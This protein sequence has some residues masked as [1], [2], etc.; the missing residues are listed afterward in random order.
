MPWVVAGVVLLS[1]TGVQAQQAPI[2]DGGGEAME[3]AEGGRGGNV[4]ERGGSAGVP[5]ITSITTDEDL[6]ANDEFTVTV[7]FSEAVDGFRGNDI[8]VDNGDVTSSVR[9]ISADEY[10]FE[11]TPD[12]DFDGVL[13]VRIRTNAVESVSTDDPNA[14]ESETF[15]VDTIE[16]TLEDAT[17]DG[18]ELVLEYSE[19]LDVN[20]VPRPQRFNVEVDGT[21]RFVNDITIRRDRVTLTLES[22]VDRGDRVRIDYEHGSGDRLQDLAGN[23]A[24]E[25]DN[26]RVTN[27]TQ[28][29]TRVPSAPR[30]LTAT[31]DGQTVIELDWRAPSSSGTGG[32]ITGYRIEVSDDGG[33][34]WE[35]EESDTGNDDTEYRHTRLRK[36]E[37]WHYRVS[38]W[39]DEGRGPVSD[40]ASATTDSDV[41]GA[42]TGL[43]ATANG[44]DR[45]DLS[46]TAPTNEGTGIIGYQIEARE[47]TSGSWT[48]LVANTNS[49]GTTY[50]HRNLDPGSTWYYRVAALSS[51]GDGPP[52]NVANATTDIGRPSAP[53]ALSATADGRTRINLAWSAPSDDG[54]APITQYRIEVSRTGTSGWLLVTRTT[55]RSYTHT[56][57]NPGSR[58]FYR[59]AAINSEGQGPFSR[60]ASA[61]TQATVPSAPS[62]LVAT[63]HGQNQINLS[64]RTPISDGGATI[65]GYRIEVSS[66]GGNNWTTRVGN[67]GNT[68]TRYEHKGLNPAST[69]HYRVYAINSAGTGPASNVANA[70][71]D[72]TVPGAPTGLTAT[73]NGQSRID[74]AW[75]APTNDGGAEITGYRIESSSN[76]TSWKT[77][78][79]NHQGTTFSNVGLAPA[80]TR[81]YRVSA[82]NVAGTGPASNIATATTDAT[83]PGPP[84]AL[85]A[86]ADGT[87]KID[88]SWT[89][90]SYDG[91]AAL[92][93][94]RIESAPNGN[95]PWTNLVANTGSTATTHSD[96]GLDPATTRYY[97]VFAINSVGSGR[98]SGVVRATT[99]A[100]VPNAPTGLNAADVSPTQI[101]LTWT[102]PAYDG[103]APITSYRVEISADGGSTWGVLVPSTA[104]TG[105]SYSHIGLE[106]GSTRHYRVSA[107]NI[108]GTGL[109][110]NV[111]SASTDDPVQR[112]GRVNAEVLPHAVAALTA[113]TVSAISGRIEAVAA[114]VPYGRQATMG[115]L[116]S[117][118]GG[119]DGAG[120]GPG[121]GRDRGMGQLFDGAS[122]LLPLG[123]SGMQQAAAG[124]IPNIAAWGSG[125]YQ[126][127]SRSRT[128]SVD[129]DGNMLNM[130]VG[131]DV[132]LR[133]DLLVGVA[134]SRSAGEFDFTDETGAS[135]VDGTY[136][137]EMTTVNPYA[138]WFL[139]RGGVVAW[140]TGGF[141]W[142]DVEI[143]DERQALRRSNTTML[144]GAV[145][146]SGILVSTGSAKLRVRAEGWMTQAEVEGSAE[147]EAMSLEVRRGRLALEWQ[148]GYRLFGGHEVSALVEGGLRYD[149]GDGG[150]GEGAEVGGGLRYASPRSRLI[151]EGRGRVLATGHFGYEEW[152]VSGMIQFDMHRRGEGLSM[153]LAPAWGEA[154]SGVQQL[155]DRGVTD[156]MGTGLTPARARLD[157]EVEYGLADF[158]GTPYGRLY[159]LDGGDRAF[160]T[161]VR[162]EISRVMNMRLE[163]TR[164]ES[165]L[166]GARHGLTL[167]G[168]LKF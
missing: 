31:A 135:E 158:G 62:N 23:E 63:A 32:D 4:A 59:V 155:W 84:T 33:T 148:Q 9:E 43:T 153:R 54:G 128:G 141:G 44:Q 82:V 73:A 24:P 138:A 127:L 152:G 18:D 40:T 88:L 136:M 96:T 161:G 87:S 1:P 157:A 97:R 64:W 162:Y 45:I 90:P 103:G 79:S 29:S 78:R 83:V 72:A 80:T 56:G 16:P 129:W 58:R 108:A 52:S 6:P 146:A 74:L 20:E 117:G 133:W 34:T 149:D 114:G 36:G 28:T 15:E 3:T 118:L 107:T 140:A 71:T 137:S 92:T 77:L 26:F 160:G 75:K 95:G 25:E 81:H 11:V 51:E 91:G 42:P 147:V 21:T 105:T 39:N 5:R 57:L 2:E 22:A 86:T 93:G 47:G 120:F 38:A 151:V 154:S 139:G 124:G 46:W 66:D 122:F 37:T 167:R 61:V 156:R 89:A 126:N 142:G 109:P 13:T 115:L 35:I 69:R 41:P 68:I 60:V 125:E 106:P 102:A 14:A 49:T 144:S 55:S 116:S 30:D 94:Y 111:A 53:L 70:T 159:M 110:S 166:N 27:N 7:V 8:E 145:G 112:A 165:V 123:G 67:T 163:A 100:T 99:D 10:E 164:R 113:S 50:S 143:E 19:N 101:D 132:Q 134:A 150:N 98:S 17:V 65:S 119:V 12:D 104:S 76:K 85:S 121:R 131:T 48:D 168:R 130:H